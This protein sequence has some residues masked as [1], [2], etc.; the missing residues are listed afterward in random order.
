[1]LTVKATENLG[2]SKTGQLLLGLAMANQIRKLGGFRVM[3][4]RESERRVE[5]GGQPRPP[6][7]PLRTEDR[8]WKC[9][10]RC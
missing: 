3:G 6:Q 9:F 10:C 7:A 8:A 2:P 5:S 1:M 4:M